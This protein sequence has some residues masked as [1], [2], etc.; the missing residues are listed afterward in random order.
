MSNMPAVPPEPNRPEVRIGTPE[1]E[2]VIEQLNA[3]FSEGRLELVEFEDR[4]GRAYVAK[5]ASELAPLTADLPAPTASSAPAR[6]TFSFQPTAS[7]RGWAGMAVV[8]IAIWAVSCIAS[9][10]LRFFWPI[11]PVGIWGAILLA[12]RITGGHRDG[13]PDDKTDDA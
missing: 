11:F 10:E 4:V 2:A 9:G 7:E 3:A 8:L 12:Q 6:K 1:R 13:E 5:F